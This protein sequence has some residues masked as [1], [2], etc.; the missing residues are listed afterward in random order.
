M[1]TWDKLSASRVKGIKTPGKYYDGGGLMLQVGA[2]RKGNPISAAWLFRFQI[3]RRERVM[4]LGS[5][6]TVTLAEARAKANEARKLLA[7]GIDP[8]AARQKERMAARAAEL[9]TATFQQCRVGFVA[10]H[11][12]AWRTKHLHQWQNSMATYC[13]PLD[14]VA[15]ADI[16]TALVL[17]CIEAEWR[18]VPETLDRVRRR[19]GEVLAWSQVRG[20]RAPG[21]LPTRWKNHLDK[22]LPHPR[23]VKP[24]EHHPAMT[25]SDVPTL[26]GS[27]ST[28]ALYLF[29]VVN[30][31]TLAATASAL[32][33]PPTAAIAKECRERAI[34]AFPRT[35]PGSAH[36]YATAQREYFRTCVSRMQR[37]QS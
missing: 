7:A 26:F 12:D 19:I 6:R 14:G 32:S 2:R 9:H 33:E 29:A 23:S 13:K 15:V 1:R 11:G 18:R 24:I 4:G 17:R 30:A 31:M 10:S 22:I 21:P 37:G 25:Y 28:K 27:M 16:D 5:A 20:L 36:G 3:D 35:P 34:N 8:L